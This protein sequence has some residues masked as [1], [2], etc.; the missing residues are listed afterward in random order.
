MEIFKACLLAEVKRKKG[1]GVLVTEEDVK[2]YCHD[3]MVEY[4]EGKFDY[5]EDVKKSMKKMLDAKNMIQSMM[6]KKEAE[7]EVSIKK[8]A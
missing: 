5:P 4:K 3:R 8:V 7:E 2:N 6:P 1:T